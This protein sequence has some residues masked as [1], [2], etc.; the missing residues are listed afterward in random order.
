MS[1]FGK[2]KK[3]KSS[4]LKKKKKESLKKK[5]IIKKQFFIWIIVHGN[6]GTTKEQ[7][8]QYKLSRWFNNRS[9]KR[10]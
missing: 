6:R 4:I 2:N 10:R 7:N 8:W 5:S 1:S 3:L 9:I